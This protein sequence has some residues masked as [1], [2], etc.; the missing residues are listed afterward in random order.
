MF[1]S[2]LGLRTAARL[3]ARD[4]AFV[5][6]AV[7]TLALGIGVNAAMFSVIRAVLLRPLPFPAPDRIVTLGERDRD[8]TASRTSFATVSDLVA[9]SRTVQVA[10]M[11]YWTPTL[12]GQGP[13]TTLEGLRVSASYFDVLG[14]RPFLGR[15]FTADEDRPE[16]ERVVIL[17][18]GIWRRRFGG[19]PAVVGRLV[20][21]SGLPHRVVGVLPAS[22]ESVFST[23]RKTPA[24]VWSPLRYAAD[25]PWACRT[26][27]HLRAVGRL[28]D[29]AS[30]D[31]AR[32]ELDTISRQLVAEHPKDY[33][34][35]GLHVETLPKALTT[36]IR[37][38]LLALWG[39]VALVLLIACANV[40]SL[41][42][43][44]ARRRERE[45][46]VRA[47]LGAGRRHLLGHLLAEA[48]L[49]CALALA[50]GLGLAVWAT[51][52]LIAAAPPGVPRIL[53]AR[54]DAG[55]VAFTAAAAA[56]CVLLFALVPARRSWRL[57]LVDTLKAGVR[58]DGARS[59]VGAREV[60]LVGDVA[61][62]LVLVVGALLLLR[63]VSHLLD[64]DPGFE[65]RG[66][67]TAEVSLSGPRY[68]DDAR[69]LAFYDE[70]LR[71]VRALPGVRGAA[72][73]SQLPLGGSTDDSGVHAED[74]PTS[75]PE[76]NPSAAR[77]GVTPGYLEALG[78]P[79]RRGR[80][81][82][83]TDTADGARVALV[84]ESLARRVWGPDD[85]L[86]RRIRIGGPAS[87]LRTVVGVVGDVRHDALDQAPPF[88]VY[89]PHTQWVDSGMVL[90]AR[91]ERPDAL[92]E[93]LPGAVRSVDGEQAVSAA[94]TMDEVLRESVGRRRWAKDLL[95][96]FAGLAV[97]LTAVGLYGLLSYA[98]AR[99]T[100]E[101]GVRLAIGARPGSVVALVLRDAARLVLPG[102]ALGLLATL[103]V[104]RALEGLVFSVTT[105]DPLTYAG[106]A[107]LLLG[108]TALA[109]LAPALRAA[110]TDPL[111]A[112]REE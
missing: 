18:H 15:H 58:A 88:Q 36:A 84:N 35:A 27:R 64:V 62:S 78:I 82:E 16:A 21:L 42:L 92:R 12:S 86:G 74:R 2:W 20:T 22:F 93:A 33:P 8:G 83:A 103:A 55:V 67:V 50:G 61:L 49:L 96:L 95:T 14:A 99:R 77:Y 11:R 5:I 34:A 59:R 29:G 105:L 68:E 26:C 52:A 19:D 37:R 98:V 76:L 57:P 100:R 110:R 91:A 24:E 63:S 112:I 89:V 43:G 13:A 106:T 38:P 102:L 65:P 7:T 94:A 71:R 60:L 107:A 66:V 80:G 32:A 28:A 90:L 10:A 101:M 47:A 4:R 48:A 81:V 51:Q 72:L 53:E 46:A 44:R 75:N 69:V 9:R 30:V 104:R 3:L 56:G 25:Q 40:V 73:A 70:A 45:M 41:L 17:G 109:A 85:P 6:V 108:V 23:N 79:L 1:G 87:P 31:Q 97:A 111:V 54:V 39:A